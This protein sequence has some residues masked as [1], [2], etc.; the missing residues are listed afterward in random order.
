MPRESKPHLHNGYW[1]TRI[2]GKQIHL[3]KNKRT[4][5][6]EFHRLMRDKLRV[7]PSDR[8]AT[9]AGAALSRSRPC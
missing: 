7:D 3:G 5:F 9:I 8:P 1:R 6:A 4:A 2:D